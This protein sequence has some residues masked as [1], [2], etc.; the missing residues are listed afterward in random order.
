M[1]DLI[2]NILRKNLFENEYTGWHKPP[3]KND[4]FP[5][6]D[7]SNYYDDDLYGPNGGRIYGHGGSAI[8]MDNT[9]ISILKTAKDR[10]EQPIKIYRAVSNKI[11]NPT[12]NIGDWVTVSLEYAKDHGYKQFDNDYVI[13]SKIVHAKDLFTDG[14]SIHEW[15]YDPN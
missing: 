8:G 11:Q 2:K 3:S 14:G 12:I 7:I 15:G 5:M 4:G 6:Y 9:T 13:L 1:K 10:P